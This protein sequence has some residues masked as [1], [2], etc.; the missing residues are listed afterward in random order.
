MAGKRV[1][2]QIAPNPLENLKGFL[3]RLEFS[4]IAHASRSD[5]FEA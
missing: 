3:R 4:P 2:G 5:Y 1:A